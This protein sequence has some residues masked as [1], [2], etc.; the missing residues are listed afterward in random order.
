M[1]LITFFTI[2][3]SALGYR[4]ETVFTDCFFVDA[5][6]HQ[7]HAKKVAM[8]INQHTDYLSHSTTATKY[9]MHTMIIYRG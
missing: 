8:S 5:A 2:F 3:V 9:G 4:V 7:S 1:K 6:C